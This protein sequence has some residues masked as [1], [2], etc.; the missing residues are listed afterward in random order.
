MSTGS[1]SAAYSQRNFSWYTGRNVE[2]GTLQILP[3]VSQTPDFAGGQTINI[4]AESVPVVKGKTRLNLALIAKFGTQDVTRH[5]AVV[6]GLNANSRYWYRVGNPEADAWSEPRVFRTGPAEGGFNFNVVADSQ[7]MCAADY[8]V[9]HDAMD[10]AARR[11]RT[12]AFTVHLGDIVDNGM[13]R[14]QWTMATYGEAVR[15]TPVIPVTGNHEVKGDVSAVTEPNALLR[16]Y[17]LQGMNVPPQDSSQ[18]IYYSF[19]YQNALFVVLNS[20]SL[21]ELNGLDATQMDWAYDELSNTDAEWKIVLL[22]KSTYSSGPHRNDSDVVRIRTQLNAL[23][24]DTGVALVLV[25]HDHTYNRND[26]LRRGSF[27]ASS[28]RTA[29]RG[30]L[31]DADQSGRYDL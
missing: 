9:C 3:Y 7:G 24:A 5:T 10:N 23:A 26:V 27:R 31:S 8:V 20:E 16:H 12:A 19:R 30:R 1:G 22:H 2:Q 21:D 4:A 6:T 11:F 25:G 13:D 18:G 15:S 17:N 14:D 29:H 28:T